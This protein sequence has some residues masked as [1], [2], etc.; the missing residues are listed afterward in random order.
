M[1]KSLFLTQLENK[2][3]ILLASRSERRKQIM[4]ALGV[5]YKIIDWQ[6]IDE[7]APTTLDAIE[8]AKYIANKKAEAY[9]P[10][11][12]DHQLV[13]ACDTIVF[14][15]QKI[16]GKPK[17]RQQAKEYLL[18][19][20]GSMHTVISGVALMTTQQRKIFEAQ[21]KVWFDKLTEEEI[22]YYIDNYKPYDKAGAYGV[23]EWIGMVGCSKI[24]GSYFN[25]MGMPIQLI[26]KELHNFI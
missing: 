20:S 26:Y 24:E 5:N 8:T 12:N 11:I 15:D 16:I 6:D 7:T 21:T 1:Q 23:Q 4:S 22:D 18:L 19:L 2:Y 10:F 13:I 25:I 14:H 17:D 3:E 9:Y